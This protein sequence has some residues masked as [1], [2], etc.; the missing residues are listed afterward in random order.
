MLCPSSTPLWAPLLKDSPGLGKRSARQA[1]I[2]TTVRVYGAATT[3]TTTLI[4]QCSSNPVTNTKTLMITLL[5][6]VPG[7]TAFSSARTTA[8]RFMSVTPS[9]KSKASS[10]KSTREKARNNLIQETHIQRV[11][12]ATTTLQELATPQLGKYSASSGTDREA[13]SRCSSR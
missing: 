5:Q 10:R 4:C 8:T 11:C 2:K 13:S 1:F 9:G 3:E 7:A 12:K 6:Q